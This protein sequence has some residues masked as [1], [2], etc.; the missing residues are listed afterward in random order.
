MQIKAIL[1]YTALVGLPVVIV[2][3]LL[4][5]GEHSLKA[6]ASVGGAWELELTPQSA[7]EPPCG[8]LPFHTDESVLTISQ[9]GPQLV[10]AFNDKNHTTLAGRLTDF[11]IAAEASNPSAPA[12]PQ[13]TLLA[14]VDRQAEP[15]RFQGTLTVASCGTTISLNATRR[16]EPDRTS[17]GH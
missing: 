13:W 5:I 15:D 4:R 1:Q 10:L 12:E 9:S 7:S 11:S 17:G 3:V 6:P 8:D 16:P 14:T 2:F